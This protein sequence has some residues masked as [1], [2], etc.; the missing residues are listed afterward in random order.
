MKH[1]ID[2]ERAKFEDEASMVKSNV[3]GFEVGDI[4]QISEKYDG[5][6]GSCMLDEDNNLLAFS[7][8]NQLDMSNNLRGFW[9]HIQTLD[10]NMFQD[11]GNRVLY[12]EWAVKHTII[13]NKDTY[14][15][16]YVYD[17]F[18]LDTN[19]WQ[20][21]SVVK[22]FAKSHGLNYI[23]V[24]YEG[25]FISWEHCKSFLHSPAYGDNQEGIVIKNQTKLNDPNCRTPF[26]LK[27][28]NDSF[29]ETQ[30]GN[31]IMKEIDPNEEI[32]KKA[33]E[34]GANQLI[35]EARIRKEINK[36]IDEGIL[37]EDIKAQDM[38]IIARNLP[39]RIYD[40]ILKED[41][42]AFNTLQN[43]YLGKAIGTVAMNYAKK[44]RA[45]RLI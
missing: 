36:M 4:I 42:E 22:E 43:K 33:A 29:K 9:N 21:Q 18:D 39:K 2:I 44:N 32:L 40:D 38:G 3:G 6:N 37:T 8:K 28:V 20:P 16:W 27:I 30:L 10:K 31:R 5:C 35:T 11:L 7:R 34:D 15:Q 26:H 14:N 24:L 1:F 13:Y 41:A 45:W 23:H 12:G 25:P 19:Q 17:M